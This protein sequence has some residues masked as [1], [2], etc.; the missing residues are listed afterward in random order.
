[1]EPADAELAEDMIP[2]DVTGLELRRRGVAAIGVADG[3]ADA[4][5]VAHS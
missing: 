2:V 4:E 5:L 3:A 1:M